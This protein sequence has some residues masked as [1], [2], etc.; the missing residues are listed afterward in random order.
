MREYV[1]EELV[2]NNLIIGEKYWKILHEEDFQY[3]APHHFEIVENME[4]QP[5]DQPDKLLCKI[6][7]QEGA[8]KDVGI[9]GILDKDLIGVV[10]CRLQHFQNSSFATREN[11]IV[12]TKLEEALMWMNKRNAN[13]VMRD[14]QGTYNK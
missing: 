5:P 9:N 3:N 14:V 8:I 12:I 4:S 11:A 10:L 13:R 7:F 2:T 6:D 1:N